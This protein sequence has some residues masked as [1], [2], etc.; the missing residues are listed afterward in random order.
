MNELPLSK[1]APFTK[2]EACYQHEV[3]NKLK[4]IKVKCSNCI[5]LAEKLPSFQIEDEPT[6]SDELSINLK[7]LILYKCTLLD[8]FDSTVNSEGLCRFF[9]N[10]EEVELPDEEVR[11]KDIVES[12]NQE[13]SVDLQKLDFSNNTIIQSIKDLRTKLINEN[14]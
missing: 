8:N 3:S 2:E 5:Y 13:M 6:I 1:F 10:L 7:Q 9:T 12:T 14:K 4:E 11:S